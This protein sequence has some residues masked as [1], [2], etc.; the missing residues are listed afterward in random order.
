MGRT[1]SVFRRISNT[2]N[3]DSTRNIGS[4]VVADDPITLSTGGNGYH[5]G[6]WIGTNNQGQYAYNFSSGFF[7]GA[8]FATAIKASTITWRYQQGNC[9]FK[10]YKNGEEIFLRI[11]QECPEVELIEECQ[12]AEEREEI[13]IDKIGYLERID[14]VN[15]YYQVQQGLLDLGGQGL[16]I[17]AQDIPEQCLNIYKLGIATIVPPGDAPVNITNSPQ[18]EFE[19]GLVAQIC[20]AVDCPPPEY[21][22]ICDCDCESCPDDTCAVPCGDSICCYAPDGIAHVTIPIESYCEGA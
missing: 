4:D 5:F 22:V 15:K 13:L 18:S 6:F 8:T 2:Q 9:I 19:L 10:V 17:V 21:E 20:S 12:L 1:R 7:S 11:N 16:F 3:R 14:V